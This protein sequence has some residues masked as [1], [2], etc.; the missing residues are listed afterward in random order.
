MEMWIFS[1]TWIL[2]MVG[3]SGLGS[4]ISYEPMSWRKWKERAVDKSHRDVHFL[5]GV[6]QEPT[7]ILADENNN[8]PWSHRTVL[9]PNQK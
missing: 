6:V 5:R 8:H 2:V 4:D 1:D 3:L 7:H 9:N